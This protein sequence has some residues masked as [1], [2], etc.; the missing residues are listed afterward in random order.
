MLVNEKIQSKWIK[1]NTLFYHN[2]AI[3]MRLLEKQA[4]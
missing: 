4:W 3:G 1:T 2:I